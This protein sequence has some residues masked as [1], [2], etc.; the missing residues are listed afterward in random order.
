MARPPG[1]SR[2]PA[3]A[4]VRAVGTS[5]RGNSTAFGFSITITVGFG[6]LT[7]LEGSPTVL[8]LFLFGTGA[9][10][11]ITLLTGI[12][13]RGFRVPVG[14]NPVEVRLL[15]TALDFLSVTVGVAT[16][17]AAGELVDGAVA[18]PLA[19]FLGVVA[20]IATESVEIY[21]AERIQ[22]ARGDPRAGSGGDGG[23]GED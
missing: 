21:A 22:R 8:E 1:E 4:P 7:R 11:A 18:W 17:L 10:L 2:E 15:G 3:T 14:E 13:S 20:F 9:A 5:I 23:D 19:V 16:V 12:V 6:M